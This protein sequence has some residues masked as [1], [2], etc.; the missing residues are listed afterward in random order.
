LSLSPSSKNEVVSQ[1]EIFQA[2]SRL[3]EAHRA[4]AISTQFKLRHYKNED[5]FSPKK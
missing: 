5:C 1:F 4:E 3:C 2:K